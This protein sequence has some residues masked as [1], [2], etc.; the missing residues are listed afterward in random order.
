M[1]IG[2][3]EIIGVSAIY[4]MSLSIYFVSEGQTTQPSTV[5]Q[6]VKL[7]LMYMYFC[8]VA[9]DWT[10]AV[11]LLSMPVEEK[12]K[13]LGSSEDFSCLGWTQNI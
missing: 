10:V 6:V 3:F 5:L 8:C 12:E 1:C 11:M 7:W 13:R 4:N 2:N 9:V